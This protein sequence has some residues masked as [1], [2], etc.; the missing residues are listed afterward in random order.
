MTDLIDLLRQLRADYSHE[1]VRSLMLVAVLVLIR[2]VVGH[3]LSSN[4]NVPVEERRRWSVSTRNCCS[5]PAWLAS[6]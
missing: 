6:A 4:V 1:I 2:L 5:F 3:I